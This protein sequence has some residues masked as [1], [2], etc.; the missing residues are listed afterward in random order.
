M[1]FENHLYDKTQDVIDK[2]LNSNNVQD[3]VQ[4]NTFKYHVLS[5]DGKTSVRINLLFYL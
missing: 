2:V 3:N 1:G 4:V 5:T